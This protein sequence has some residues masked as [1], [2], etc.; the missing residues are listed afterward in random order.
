MIANQ[1][2][3][4]AL[5]QSVVPLYKTWA[6]T[7]ATS[8][9]LFASSGET[10]QLTDGGVGK[11]SL[12]IENLTEP[13]EP[14]RQLDPPVEHEVAVFLNALSAAGQATIAEFATC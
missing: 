1:P 6:P 10:Q 8:C 2:E 4:V 12:D 3:P 7:V 14:H 11:I 13:R 5:F 9:I